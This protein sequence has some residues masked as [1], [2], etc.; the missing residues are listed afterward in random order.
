MITYTTVELVLIWQ[1]QFAVASIYTVPL[2]THS[3]LISVSLDKV[4]IA[5]GSYS[6][7]R[8]LSLLFK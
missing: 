1:F 7:L 6:D 5:E 3:K 2:N 4:M 8:G